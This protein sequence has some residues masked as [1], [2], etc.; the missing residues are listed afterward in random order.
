[1]KEERSVESEVR[2]EVWAKVMSRSRSKE[3]EVTSVRSDKETITV[4]DS[5]T[6]N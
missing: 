3:Q 2:R 1:M 5:E 4:T 6:G